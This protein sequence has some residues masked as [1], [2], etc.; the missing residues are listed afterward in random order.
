MGWIQDKTIEQP[1]SI[2]TCG[3][4]QFR[5]VPFTI[6]PAVAEAA[7]ETPA[8]LLH[9][10]LRAIPSRKKNYRASCGTRQREGVESPSV[11]FGYSEN[12]ESE[13]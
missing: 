5:M 6:G 7:A 10:Q 2:G 8:F 4:S 3:P 13:R 11:I 9:C 12:H 1:C